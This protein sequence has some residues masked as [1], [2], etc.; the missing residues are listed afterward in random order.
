MLCQCERQKVGREAWI[1][2]GDEDA[3]ITFSRSLFDALDVLVRDDL[4]RILQHTRRRSDDVDARTQE[5]ADVGHRLLQ[6]D[7]THRA[8]DDTL[9]LGGNDGVEIIGRHDARRDVQARQF[10]GVLADLRVRRHPDPRQLEALVENQ[11]FQG[12]AAAVA[13]AD[14]R[15]ANRH[16]VISFERMGCSMR[17]ETQN[18]NRF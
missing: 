14:E 13:G 8:V 15:D 16:A 2:A 17:A 9:G 7:V 4:P 1:D 3:R 12:E 5:R 10:T 6:P 11:L 18:W